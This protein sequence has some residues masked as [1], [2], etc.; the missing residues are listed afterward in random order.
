MILYFIEMWK[1]NMHRA[2]DIIITDKIIITDI[3][4]IRNKRMQYNN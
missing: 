1:S 3:I 4:I 2:F